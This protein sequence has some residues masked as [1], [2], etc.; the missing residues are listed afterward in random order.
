MA[1]D[2]A[3]LELQDSQRA[4][5]AVDRRGQEVLCEHPTAHHRGGVLPGNPSQPPNQPT[6]QPLCAS[7]SPYPNRQVNLDG[8]V[9]SVV[10]PAGAVGGEKVVVSGPDPKYTPLRPAHRNTNSNHGATASSSSSSGGGR[11]DLAAMIAGGSVLGG[12]Q[13]PMGTL[14]QTAAPTLR[15]SSSSSSDKLHDEVRSHVPYAIP[16]TS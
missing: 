4:G 7:P 14:L 3:C 16:A 6:N 15:S 9:Y 8:R 10:S 13:A 11:R 12:A 1:D 2:N 5:A